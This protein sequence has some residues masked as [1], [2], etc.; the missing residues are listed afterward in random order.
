MAL[1][2]TG[3]RPELAP[4]ILDKKASL[5]VLEAVYEC[6]INTWDTANTYCNDLS[7]ER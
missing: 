2:S 3:N 5:E 7:K 1:G 4:W 6:G